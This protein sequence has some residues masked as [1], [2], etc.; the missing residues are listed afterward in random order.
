MKVIV[1]YQCEIC[2]KKYEQ[3]DNAL[4]CEG[5]GIADENN[6]DFI[7]LMYEHV[8]N[9]YVGIF[10]IGRISKSYNP[11]QL[12]FSSWAFRCDPYPLR[13]ID[14]NFCGSG[15]DYVPKDISNFYGKITKSKVGNREFNLMVDYLKSKGIQPKYL[16]ENKELIYV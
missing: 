7:G 6:M 15:S 11:H 3:K 1:E 10:A 13:T 12:E 14:D 16:N 8:H 4:E 5:K 2:K 9:G